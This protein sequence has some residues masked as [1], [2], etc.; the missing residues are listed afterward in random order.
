M[1]TPDNWEALKKALTDRLEM[2]RGVLDEAGHD[3]VPVLIPIEEVQFWMR[4]LEEHG[5]IQ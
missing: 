5:A 2:A 3:A 1:T 4:D